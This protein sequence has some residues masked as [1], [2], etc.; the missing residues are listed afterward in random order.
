MIQALL[1]LLRRPALWQRTDAAFWDDEHISQGMLAAH[2]NPDLDAASRRQV[3]MD[4]SVQWLTT[5][6]KPGAKLLD[7]GC[8][9]GFYTKPLA[10]LGFAVTGMDISE[11]SLAY[12]QS[13]DE[14]SAYL[15]QNYLELDEIQA[16]DAILLIYCD[17]A[18]LTRDERR[19]L[20]TKVY[21]ALKPGGLFIFDVFTDRHFAGKSECATWSLQENGG[22]WCAG[23]HLCLEAT[24][25]YE[26]GMV[27]ADQ[28]VILTEAGATE[29]L[30]WDTAFTRESLCE[31]VL[32]AG[33]Q[34]VGLY[35]D[36][37][38]AAYTGQS[39]TLCAVLT[40]D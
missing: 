27:S 32:P 7:L 34:V 35:D 36:V 29:Y 9:P 17:Y 4:R 25:L 20:L 8:G 30:I 1:P 3:T 21:Q 24:Y 15:R 12:A 26:G 37:C 6:L 13:Q 23:P 14:K 16:F 11:R 40:R 10:S 31:E 33:F 38:G 22:F 2:L 39:D 18:A 28:C 5:L 19:L